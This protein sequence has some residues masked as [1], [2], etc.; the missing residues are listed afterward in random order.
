[1]KISPMAP[2]K[3]TAPGEGLIVI[4]VALCRMGT[5]SLA[6]AYRTL[7]YKVHHG[8]ENIA[9]IPWVSIEHA[10]EATWPEVAPKRSPP[11]PPFTR[12]DWD[13]AW[14]NEYDITTEMA[15][16]FADQLIKAYPEA[17]VVIVQREFEP[18]WESFRCEMLDPLF[19][20]VGT[21]VSF[22]A[23][24]I[25]GIRAGQTMRKVHFGFFGA[26]NRDEIEA[27]ARKTYDQYYER[28]RSLVPAEN[29]L[30]YKLGDGWG[31]LCAYLGKDIPDVPFPFVNVRKSHSETAASQ[32]DAVM[33]KAAWK[34]LSVGV[35]LA[36]IGAAMWYK[37]GW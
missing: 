19:S 4:H 17:K 6:E 35:G 24:H 8:T 36:A 34:I 32:R 33:V 5:G 18:W 31:P 15:S 3:T 22:I 29:R 16:P 2:A 30:E 21:I 14:G 10:A 27:N 13:E 37:Q 20:P 28:I 26:R 9:G 1:M 23:A 25:M 7:G 12:A 11:R